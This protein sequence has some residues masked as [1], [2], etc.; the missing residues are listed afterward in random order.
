MS[1]LNERRSFIILVLISMFLS[2]TVLLIS[3]H[4]RQ[5]NNHK[6][7]D[8]LK[9]SASFK[10]VKPANPKS[11]TYKVEEI[12]WEGYQKLLVLNQNLGC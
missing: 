7:C 5:Q 11:K 10:R 2:L 9:Y 1:H 8:L 6:F 4:A 3:S 12:Q